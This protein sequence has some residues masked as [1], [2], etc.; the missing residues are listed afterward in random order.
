MGLINKVRN[1]FK[2][3]KKIDEMLAVKMDGVPEKIKKFGDA[4]HS[5]VVKLNNFVNE[6]HKQ[7]QI[8]HE[9]YNS[10]LKAKYPDLTQ[11]D[12]D[13]IEERSNAY[14]NNKY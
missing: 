1:F 10:E 4:V 3:Y 7:Q 8:E 2:K 6:A 12:W 9:K 5:K 13:Y 14:K 11:E